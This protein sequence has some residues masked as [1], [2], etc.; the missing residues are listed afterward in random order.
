MLVHKVCRRAKVPRFAHRRIGARAR[1]RSK[2]LHT[3]AQGPK[4]EKLKRLISVP[5]ALDW[6]PLYKGSFW[7]IRSL[8]VEEAL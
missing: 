5:R 8:G 6:P 1:D 2:V 7:C 4:I 3:L